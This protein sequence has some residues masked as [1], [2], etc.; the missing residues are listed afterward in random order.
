MSVRVTMSTNTV[1]R[2]VIEQDVEDLSGRV[3]ELRSEIKGLWFWLLIVAV[4]AFVGVVMGAGG[5]FMEAEARLDAL[6]A[7]HAVEVEP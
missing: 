2:S 7:Q 6:E 3:S 1:N 5:R 4:G